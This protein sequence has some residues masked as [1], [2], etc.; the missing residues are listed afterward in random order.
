MPTGIPHVFI[1]SITGL[2]LDALKDLLWAELNEESNK[3]E[4]HIESMAHRPK[5]M[6]HLQEE[7]RE[8]GEDED[9]SVEYVNEDEVEDLEDFEYEEDWDETEAE[10]DVK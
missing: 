2:G 5:D 3:I 7:L 8:E 6:S 9:L 1:S 4:G 10:E